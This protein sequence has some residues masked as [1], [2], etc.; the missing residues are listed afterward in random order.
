[1]EFLRKM[2]LKIWD[3]YLKAVK[4]VSHPNSTIYLIF[5]D[6][7]KREFYAYFLTKYSLLKYSSKLT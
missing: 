5:Y 7:E 4:N 1:M 3:L 6:V 2:Q